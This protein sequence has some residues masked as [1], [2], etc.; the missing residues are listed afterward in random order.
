MV[1]CLFLI[2]G[3]RETKDSGFV[4]GAVRA[5]DAALGEVSAGADKGRMSK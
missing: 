4:V 5:Q 2:T 3:A 1:G